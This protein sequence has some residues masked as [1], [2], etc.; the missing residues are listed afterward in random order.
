MAQLLTAVPDG[1]T[2]T[3]KTSMGK[4]RVVISSLAGRADSGNEAGQESQGWAN[5]FCL[6]DPDRSRDDQ[7]GQRVRLTGISEGHTL[8][9][10]QT[11][12]DLVGR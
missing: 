4:P 2:A 1:A 11:V 3:N 6:A 7:T 12:V 9:P 10:L 8:M 5:A